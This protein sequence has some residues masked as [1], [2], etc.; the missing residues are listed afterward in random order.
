[1]GIIEAKFENG[2]LRPLRRLS[3]RAGE[4]VGIFVVRHPDPARWVIARLSKRSTEDEDLA[5]G[6]IDE[7]AAALDLEDR[8]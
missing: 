1:M 7:W 2:V 8:R 6:G 5:K 4:Q 3:L